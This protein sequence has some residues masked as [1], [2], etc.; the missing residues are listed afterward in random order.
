[1]PTPPIVESA[2]ATPRR[3]HAVLESVGSGVTC[4]IDTSVPDNPEGVEEAALYFDR[5]AAQFGGA[6]DGQ[7]IAGGL[8]AHDSKKSILT[9]AR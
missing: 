8:I 1:M 5:L 3:S 2:K 6:L 9:W 4:T 7:D